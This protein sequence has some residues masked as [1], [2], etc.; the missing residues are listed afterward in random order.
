ME[1]LLQVHMHNN[2]DLFLICR[3]NSI[4]YNLRNLRLQAGAD[5][6]LESYGHPPLFSVVEIGNTEAAKLMLKYGAD[7]NVTHMVVLHN[8]KLL[9]SNILVVFIYF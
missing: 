1:R 4:C 8:L 6:N 5:P 2:I 3:Q 7:A 9:L